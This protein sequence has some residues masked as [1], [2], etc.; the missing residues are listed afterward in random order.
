MS[1]GPRTS[2]TDRQWEK[3]TGKKINR[4]AERRKHALERARLIVYLGMEP[5][6]YPYQYAHTTGELLKLAREKSAERH[7]ARGRYRR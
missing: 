4:A 3:I 7:K 6:R 2:I 5:E 1:G